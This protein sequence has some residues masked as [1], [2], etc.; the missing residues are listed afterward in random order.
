LNVLAQLLHGAPLSSTLSAIVSL[1]DHLDQ[2]Q[3]WIKD[4]AGRYCAIN[5]EFLLN[6]SFR[7]PDQV[8]GKSDFD[9]SPPYLAEKYRID[10]ERVLAGQTVSG[11]IELVGR[12]D[13]TARWCVT[14]KVPLRDES[15]KIYGTAGITMPLTGK[16]IA[17]DVQDVAIAKV[18]TLLHERYAER[19]S[20]A[21]LA[22]LANLSVRAFERRFLSRIGDSAQHYVRRVRVREATRLLVFSKRS[23]ADIAADCGFADQSHFTREF[24][25]ETKMTPALYRK[26]YA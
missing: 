8:V 20:N 1:F 7:T 4:Q 18:V 6:Y 14:H 3:F 23:L 15:G 25:R 16:S 19:W 12:F 5:R 22:K 24:R 11:R 17:P 2:V 9:L 10:D 13:H 26:R 21:S